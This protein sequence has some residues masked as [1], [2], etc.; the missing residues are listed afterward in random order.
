MAEMDDRS[1][2]AACAVI[3]N[4]AKQI[5]VPESRQA[6]RQELAVIMK[7]ADPALVALEI[8]TMMVGV[9]VGHLAARCCD[10]HLGDLIEQTRARV[11]GSAGESEA[12]GGR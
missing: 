2:L 1:R 7:D 8:A 11:L 10:L 9:S 6:T 3:E 4:A 5:G 12:V